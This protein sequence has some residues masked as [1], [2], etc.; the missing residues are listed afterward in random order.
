VGSTPATRSK[1]CVAIPKSRAETVQKTIFYDTNTLIN[2]HNRYLRR[3]FVQ[4]PLPIGICAHLA[5]TSLADLCGKQR[6]KS[7]PPKPNRFVAFV[8]AGFV[9]KILGIPE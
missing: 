8:D 7:V 6:A 4:V 2:H 1:A 5:D 3:Q 9:Q